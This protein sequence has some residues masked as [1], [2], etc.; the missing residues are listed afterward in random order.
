MVDTNVLVAALRS[1]RGASYRLLTMLNDGRWQVNISTALIFEYEE[2]LKR[3]NQQL[4]L[5]FRE[6]DAIIRGICSIANQYEI[7]YV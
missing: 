5:S 7:F 6:I 3:E 1:N 4:G 2:V